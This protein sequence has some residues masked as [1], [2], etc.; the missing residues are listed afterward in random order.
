MP[1]RSLDQLPTE[2]PPPSET[3]AI[4]QVNGVTGT[5]SVDRKYSLG[6]EPQHK[7][8]SRPIERTLYP[9]KFRVVRNGEDADFRSKLVSLQ[10]FKKGDL[11]CKIE[12]YAKHA[13]KR[14]SSVQVSANEHIE[15]CSELVYMNHSCDPSIHLD[16]TRMEVIA[17]KDIKEGDDL[18]FFYPSSE[19]DMSQPFDC[20]CGAEQC[21]KR[22]SGAQHIPPTILD[23]Y[24]LN[25]HIREALEKKNAGGR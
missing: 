4:E 3:M 1:A 14:W 18:T 6:R 23:R 12:G 22:V 24:F 13:N 21:V 19:W 16:T 11:V 9:T 10:P 20:W 25:Q 7:D 5:S 17:A 2:Q 8:I 15:L